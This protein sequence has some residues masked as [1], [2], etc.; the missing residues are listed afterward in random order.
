VT[1]VDTP[2]WSLAFR[3]PPSRLNPRELFLKDKLGEL[4]REGTAVLMGPV[5]Q[6]V[7][8]GIRDDEK[9]H[10]LREVLRALPDPALGI[11]DYEEA[12]RAFN[13]CQRNGIAGS[14]TDFLICALAVR[15]GWEVLTTDGD[16]QLYAKRLA[17]RLAALP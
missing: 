17:F 9:F 15:R 1:I 7:L 13:T 12:A 2:L 6:E 10:V 16:F 4:I 3:R 11:E 5:R 14:D 8:S